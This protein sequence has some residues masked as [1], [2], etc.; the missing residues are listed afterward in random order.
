MNNPAGKLTKGGALDHPHLCD[1]CNLPRNR[2][3]HND[4]SRVRQERYR[5]MRETES[6]QQVDAR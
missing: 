5:R 6:I 4:C 3:K 1:V 2:G